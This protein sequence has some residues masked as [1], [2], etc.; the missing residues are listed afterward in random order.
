MFYFGRHL[1]GRVD[2]Y[3]EISLKRESVDSILGRFMIFT[4]NFEN[5]GSNS[6]FDKF[7]IVVAFCKPFV[8]KWK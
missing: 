4:A 6:V 8:E 5:T 7:K 2:F 1:Q 3:S